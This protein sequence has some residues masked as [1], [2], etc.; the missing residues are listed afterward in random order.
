MRV[1]RT[2]AGALREAKR[3]AQVCEAVLS[4][5]MVSLLGTR[6]VCRGQPG[7][8]LPVREWS[9]GLVRA[10]RATSARASNC[11]GVSTRVDLPAALKPRG[12]ARTSGLS[13]NC[14]RVAHA[15]P[16]VVA[17]GQRLVAGQQVGLGS[18]P[19]TLAPL[20]FSKNFPARR[21][22][23]RCLFYQPFVKVLLRFC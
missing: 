20:E 21:S 22:R 23:L 1:R 3:P 18:R 14:A 12:S 5:R 2:R 9:D 10:L 16:W 19:S 13:K 4:E 15:R 11:S 8:C 17:A 7:A 6:G